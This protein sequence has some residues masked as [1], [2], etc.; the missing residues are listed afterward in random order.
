[1][2][3]GRDGRRRLHPRSTYLALPADGLTADPRSRVVLRGLCARQEKL[4]RY[5]GGDAGAT[6][7]ARSISVG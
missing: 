7:G 5:L 3:R 4:L 6:G 2:R 1:V